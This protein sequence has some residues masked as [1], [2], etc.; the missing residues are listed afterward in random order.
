MIVEGAAKTV[1]LAVLPFIF[2]QV[3]VDKIIPVEGLDGVF[4]EK[5]IPQGHVGGIVHPL[6]FNAFVVI[7]SG[8]VGVLGVQKCIVKFKIKTGRGFQA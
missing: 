7:V 8:A 3:I 1:V 4:V 2:L 5:L 6:G